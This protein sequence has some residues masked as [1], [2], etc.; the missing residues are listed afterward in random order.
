MTEAH[1][2]CCL[3]AGL[4]I[5]G[6]NAEVAPSQWEYQIGIAEGIEGGDH[7]WMSRYLLLRL[8]EEFGV[9]VVFEPKPIVGDWN[10]SGCHTNFSCESSRNED[11]FKWILEVAMPRL[12]AKHHEHIYLY[13]EGNRKRLTGKH[14]TASYTDFSYGVGS[15]GCSVRI[16]V[17]TQKNGCGYFEDRRPASNIDPYLVT[18]IVSDSV[19][20]ES[21]Y[22]DQFIKLYEKSRGPVEAV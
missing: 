9:D 19:I 4:R 3:A 2:R 12:K 18:G 17:P 7:L 1:L 10:G 21:K 22:C 15:R 6:V 11:G 20:L 5:S 16:P 13:G 14:E 8:G